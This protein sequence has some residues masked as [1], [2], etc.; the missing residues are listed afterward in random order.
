MSFF[1][2]TLGT[3]ALHGDDGDVRLNAKELALLV[4]LRVTGRPHLRGSL[5]QLLWTN[6]AIGRNNSVNTAISSL[7]RALPSGALPTGAAR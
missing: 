3:P 5:G 1:L 7:R 4:Y 6:I 2:R